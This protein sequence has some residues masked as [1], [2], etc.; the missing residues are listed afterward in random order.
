M[1]DYC[2]Q[3][4]EMWP[5]LNNSQISKVTDSFVGLGGGC[6]RLQHFGLNPDIIQKNFICTT[7][8]G[9]Q[10]PIDTIMSFY[11]RIE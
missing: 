3:N 11:K 1:F 4:L 8:Q 7:A 5:N 6:L 2:A 10:Y 9:S